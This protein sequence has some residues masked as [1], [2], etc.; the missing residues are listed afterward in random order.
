[1]LPTIAPPFVFLITDRT[2]VGGLDK[3]KR[4]VAAAIEGGVHGIQIREK[5]LAFHDL[6]Q[7]TKQ[8]RK[9][10]ANQA[11]LTLNV[12]TLEQL[13]MGLE[14]AVDGVHLGESSLPIQEVQTR[15]GKSGLLIGSSV[16]SLESAIEAIHAG[17][18]FLQVGTLFPSESHP[19]LRNPN[20]SIMEDLRRKTDIPLIGVGGITTRNASTVINDGADGI[21]V[22]REILNA[23]NPKIAAKTLCEVVK[24]AYETKQV[25]NA[26]KIRPK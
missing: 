15:L 6:E 8:L 11:V 10:T 23:E 5:D 24:V 20:P 4:H 12:S 9:I 17:A 25:L 7:I 21:A 22:I 1:M 18:D 14:C 26:R 3:L 2:V 13:E 19:G 16:H